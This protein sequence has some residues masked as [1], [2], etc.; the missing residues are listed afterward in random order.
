MFASVP[1]PHCTK[2]NGIEIFVE[3]G[4]L[5][6]GGREEGEGNKVWSPKGK[7]FLFFQMVAR[8]FVTG[9]INSCQPAILGC[10]VQK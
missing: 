7:I 2:V 3:P 9:F 4:N 6:K 8:Q 5:P 1:E 10:P